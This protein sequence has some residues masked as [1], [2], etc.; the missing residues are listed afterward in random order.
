MMKIKIHNFISERYD[1]A[2][3]KIA[4]IAKSHLA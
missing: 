4:G 1:L 3:V 2:N